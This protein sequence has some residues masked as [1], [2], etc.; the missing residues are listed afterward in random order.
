MGVN[1]KNIQQSKSSNFREKE[2]LF[3][4]FSAMCCGPFFDKNEFNTE[5]KAPVFLF[6]IYRQEK[7]RRSIIIGNINNLYYL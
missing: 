2:W 6:L 7:V 4:E 5:S 1:A 3:E